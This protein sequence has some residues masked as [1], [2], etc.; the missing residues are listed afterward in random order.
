MPIHALTAL[1]VV[2]K[3]LADK[4]AQCSSAQQEVLIVMKLWGHALSCPA[5]FAQAQDT[6]CAVRAHDISACTGLC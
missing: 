5:A 2:L 4:P 3:Q 6:A 1:A